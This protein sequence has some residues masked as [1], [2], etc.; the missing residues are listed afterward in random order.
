MSCKNC[1]VRNCAECQRGR[2]P[3][4]DAYDACEGGE[5][6]EGEY[7]VAVDIG[8][9][10]VVCELINIKTAERVSV[11]SCM[12][13]QREY[14]RDVL[15]RISRAIDRSAAH[16]HKLILGDIRRGLAEFAGHEITR[17]TI[18]GNT[19]MLHLLHNLPC[20]G[21]GVYPFTPVSVASAQVDFFG[22]PATILPGVSAF[23]GAD[24]VAGLYNITGDLSPFW[25]SGTAS[26]RTFLL[27]DLGTNG[28]MVLFDGERFLATS[29]AAGPAFESGSVFLASDVI[30]QCAE[31][32]RK[33][34]VDETGRL[35]GEAAISQADIREVQLAKAA[36]RAGIQMLLDEAGCGLH[37]V[38]KVFLA[39][40]FGYTMDAGD[41][42]TL[43][44]LPA[45]L[46]VSK[47]QAVGNAALGGTAKFL[48]RPDISEIQK[49]AASVTEINLATHPQF[50]QLFLE[51]LNF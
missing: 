7:G 2:A 15:A 8:T 4:L 12:N 25:G 32:V 1:T 26:P 40:G 36:V 51:H 31:L 49:I 19:T 37:C 48:L 11:F 43:G 20:D 34:V 6:R 21:L 35:C 50:E 18:C 23:I 33:G 45:G 16:M 28:E 47:I 24:I 3:I 14:G 39:G 13:S 22:C 17:I 30:S 10:T 29:V 44:L 41:A 27:I 38:D 46:P 5:G 9:T 42:L